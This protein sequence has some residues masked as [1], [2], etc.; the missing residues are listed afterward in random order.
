M[1]MFWFGYGWQQK[2]LVAAP[3]LPGCGGEWKETGRKLVGRD[4]GSLTEQQTKGTVTATIQIRRKHNTN[5]TAQSA[6]LP[7]QTGAACS[8]AASEFPPPSSPPPEPSIT[9]HGME[10]PALF[11]QVGSAHLAVPLPGFW[12]KLTL[13]W[14][15]PGQNIYPFQLSVFISSDIKDNEGILQMGSSE[16]ARIWIVELI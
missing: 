7:D 15:N 14:P 8:Q 11:G 12:S 4:K 3:P 9:A 16:F 1:N 13:S 10:Y 6:I 2:R 5:R